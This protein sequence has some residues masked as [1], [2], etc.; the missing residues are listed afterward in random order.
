VDT[1]A[2]HLAA[3]CQCPTIALFGPSP[4]FEY[5]PWHVKHQMIRP[6]DW[7]SEAAAKAMPCDELM[8]EI[9]FDRVLTACEE[10]WKYASEIPTAN[11]LESGP[12]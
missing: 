10:A 1:A 9:P 5:H 4:V 12:A 6:Q 11:S 2:M 8:R 7:L 3:A